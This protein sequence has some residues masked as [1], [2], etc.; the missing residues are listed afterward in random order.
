MCPQARERG[1]LQKRGEPAKDSPWERQDHERVNFCCSRPPSCGVWPQ[2]S[3]KVRQPN[4]GTAQEQ[5]S[6]SC[7]GWGGSPVTEAQAE[8]RS[9]APRTFT[10][11]KTESHLAKV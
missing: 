5:E 3:R 10:L 6:L 2:Q 1:G 11:E 8:G 9:P 7:G 4:L